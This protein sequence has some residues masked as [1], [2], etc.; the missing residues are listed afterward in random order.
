MLDR[1]MAATAVQRNELPDPFHGWRDYPINLAAYD[2]ITT[3]GPVL[4]KRI[5]DLSKGLFEDN[6]KVRLIDLEE[7][8]GELYHIDIAQSLVLIL[9]AFS[10][11]R[12]TGM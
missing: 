3:S 5:R 1:F 12:K 10:C 4:K 11:S 9:P 2:P 7:E 8:K 6:T